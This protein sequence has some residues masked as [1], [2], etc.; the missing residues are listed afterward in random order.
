M[1]ATAAS[2]PNEEPQGSAAAS[3]SAIA[4]NGST[5][6][7][8]ISGEPGPSEAG[9]SSSAPSTS[10]PAA[11]EGTLLKAFF[12]G[13]RD[14]DRENEVHR[15]LGAFKLN[16][17]EQLGLRFDASVED[18]KKAYRKSSLMVHPDKC[19]HPKAQDA[20]EILGQAQQQLNNEEKMK[21]LLYVL[22][23]AQD[24]VLKEWRK[25]T[26]NDAATR[27]ASVLHAEGQKGV[28]AK[29]IQSPEYHEAWK[30]QAR[31][32]LARAEFRKRKLTQRLKD[33]TARCEE[34][35]AEKKIK[36]KAMREH[37]HK[38]EDTREGRVGTWRDFVKGK[39]T[40]SGKEL[41]LGGIKP[42][43]AKEWDQDKTYMQRPV[44]EQFRP[45]PPKGPQTKQG[46]GRQ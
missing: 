24:Q 14:V 43:K 46:A 16:P 20:F 17:F 25:K 10:A 11:D 22:T 2:T 27:L 42:P 28:E 7:S 9:T 31:D 37:H 5:E 33:D 41:V 39:K 29:Y 38:W 8:A 6:P 40:R 30:V 18:V 15:I 13:M 21:E 32:V 26:K 19:K 35:E 12:Q 34:D 36:L 4:G 3:S 45:P 44:G 1:T 23:L